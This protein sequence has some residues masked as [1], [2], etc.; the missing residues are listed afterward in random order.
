VFFQ[1]VAIFHTFYPPIIK[2]N[3]SAQ[4]SFKKIKD[5]SLV[6]TNQGFA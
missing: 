1:L 4:L 6:K 5:K 3:F 2:I